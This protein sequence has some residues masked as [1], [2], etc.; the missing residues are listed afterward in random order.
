M[1]H[2]E[3]SKKYHVSVTDMNENGDGFVR[4]DRMAVFIP[5]LVAGDTAD[6]TLTES[7]KNYA[8]GQCDA[9]ITPSEHRIAPQC[10]AFGKCGGCTL[11][12]VTYEYENSVKQ[13]CVKSALRRMKLPFDELERELHPRSAG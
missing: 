6:V 7:R 12:H 13:N 8:V 5:G 9:L 1:K 2:P 10:P 3:S 11:C 4:I